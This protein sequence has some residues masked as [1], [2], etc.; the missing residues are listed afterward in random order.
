MQYPVI[1]VCLSTV[2]EEDRLYFIRSLNQHAVANG[3]RLMIFQTCSD[4][5]DTQTASNEGEITVFQ[6]IP[7]EKLS[8]MILLPQFLYNHPLLNRVI[9]ECRARKIPVISIDRQMLGCTCFAF[10][11]A[12]IFEQLCRH[13]I[14]V[15][16]AKKLM[17]IAGTKGNSFSESRIAAFRKAVTE[18]GLDF[19]ESMIGYGDF[20]NEPTEDALDKW[21]VIEKRPLPDA[22]ICANDSMAITVTNWLQR[23]GYRVPE[24]CIVTGFDGIQQA[25]YHVPHLTTCQQDYD[26]MGRELIAVIGRLRNGERVPVYN[27]IGF[28]MHL[29]QSCGCE[30]IGF[31]NINR[32]MDELFQRVRIVNNRQDMMC[33]LQAAISE[34]KSVEELSSVLIEKFVFHTSIFAVNDDLFRVPDFGCNHRK[35][36]AFSEQIDV[37]YHR[38]FWHKKERCTIPRTE[39]IPDLDRMLRREEPVIVCV[40]HHLDLVLGYCVFQTE[41]SV[42]EY[43]K[44]F[45]FMS[46]VNASFGAFHSRMQIQAINDQLKSVNA[47]LEKLY[48]HDYLTGLYNRRGFYKQFRLMQEAQTTPANAFLISADLDRLKYINDSFGH[49]EGD[50]A[51]CT[52][53]QA[54]LHAAG[55]GDIVARFGGDEFAVG[56]ILPAEDAEAHYA[57]F[58]GKFLRYLEKYNELSQNPYPVEASIGYYAEA[59]NSDFDLDNMIKVADDRMYAEKL[60]HKKARLE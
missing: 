6:L 57:A 5:F 51:I 39:L 49:L 22:I 18:S 52:I 26:K 42:N 59:L 48:V 36:L 21:F 56:G 29:S 30:K 1:G 23:K 15:H 2:Q 41:I 4:L 25:E 38:Y 16:H 40:L 24:D 31:R 28:H 13:V 45:T 44:I 32:A 47:E 12:D 43:E 46:A 37:I 14:D 50:N 33:T 3:Y 58:R 27:V 9:S 55:E 8:A 17:M 20:W 53:A 35:D 10:A 54:L 60:L 11:Y 7:Y 34:M 19:D